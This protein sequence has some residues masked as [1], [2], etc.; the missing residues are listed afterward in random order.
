MIMSDQ[1]KYRTENR[2]LGSSY[3]NLAT[4]LNKIPW[5]L[6]PA[7]KIVMKLYHVSKKLMIK[8]WTLGPHENLPKIL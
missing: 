3:T 6:I 2:S 4:R 8:N 1:T 7:I 5:S